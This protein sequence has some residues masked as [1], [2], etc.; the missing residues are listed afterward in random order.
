MRDLTPD[1]AKA[2]LEVL[3]KQPAPDTVPGILKARAMR[4]A[5]LAK[6]NPKKQSRHAS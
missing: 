3:D 1:E 6:A 5:L 4:E 2:A